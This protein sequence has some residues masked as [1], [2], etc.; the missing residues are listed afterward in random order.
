MAAK[1]TAC[2]PEPQ[3]RLSVMP[4]VPTG[5]PAA[6]TRHPADAAPWSPAEV[7]VADD[8]VVDV[9]RVEAGAVGQRVEALREQ[10]LRVDVVQRAVRPCPCRAACAPRR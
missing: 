8:H 5:Q 9:V 10:L 4:G 2:W 6:S 7:A 3:K 1:V